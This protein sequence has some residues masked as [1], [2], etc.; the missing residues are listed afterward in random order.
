MNRLMLLAAGA[1]ALTLAAC[2]RGAEV[3]ME[4]DANGAAL[5]TI[6]KLDCPE[7]EG[8][9]ERVSVAA[10]GLSCAY[11]TETAE[12][13]LR[14][15]ALAGSDAQSVLGPIETELQGIVPKPKKAADGTATVTSTTETVEGGEKA[16]INLPGL[17]I[18]ADDGGA[19]IRVGNIKIDANDNGQTEVK[20]GENTIVNADDGN[21]EIRMAKSKG[22]AVRATYILAAENTASGYDVVGYEARGPKA[23]PIV[24]AVVKARE[25]KGRHDVFDD[26]KDLVERNVGE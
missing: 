12:V 22:D 26:M 24:V 16:E 19:K 21:A 13:T 14:L 4:D 18:N 2:D 1:A 3:R 8:K 23:G 6:A 25:T 5:R 7:K 11:K 10:D 15:V 20:V 17:H 9:L